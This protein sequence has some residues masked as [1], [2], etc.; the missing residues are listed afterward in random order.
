MSM[1][2]HG[3]HFSCSL[4]AV[5]I[6]HVRANCGDASVERLLAEAKS[7]RTLEYLEDLGNWI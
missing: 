4:S 7:P 5:I 6:D 3:N 1:T 2:D